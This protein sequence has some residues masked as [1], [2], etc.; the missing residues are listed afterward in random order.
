MVTRNVKAWT[1]NEK[2][3]SLEIQE[4]GNCRAAYVTTMLAKSVILHS[5]LE[6]CGKPI[7]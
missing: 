6:L 7:F 3:S 4:A 5:A 1:N 2:N